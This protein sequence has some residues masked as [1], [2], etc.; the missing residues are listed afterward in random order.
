MEE[1]MKNMPDPS[2]VKVRSRESASIVDQIY[3][4]DCPGAFFPKVPG[5]SMEMVL[6][7][8]PYSS[9]GLPSSARA[10]TTGEKYVLTS[11]KIV[12][13]IFWEITGIRGAS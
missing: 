11:T 4:G 7:E 13:L 6:T 8:P 10:R 3:Q 1:V 2:G 12:H 5:Q 9:G